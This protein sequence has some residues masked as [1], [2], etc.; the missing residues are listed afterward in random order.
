MVTA[1]LSVVGSAVVQL[2]QEFPGSQ[3]RT[4]CIYCKM[5]LQNKFGAE[6]KYSYFENPSF[7]TIN[8]K[9]C[10]LQK[11][12]KENPASIFP[13]CA[14]SLSIFIISLYVFLPRQGYSWYCLSVAVKKS[15]RT[16]LR[17]SK[18]GLSSGFSFQHK[19]MTL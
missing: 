10:I 9:T 6:T 16:L 5:A 3:L 13:G 12:T 17:Y 2:L 19:H 7:Y 4:Y 14:F 1:L 18:V 11:Q 15:S 8:I